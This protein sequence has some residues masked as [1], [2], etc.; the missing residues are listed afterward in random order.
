MRGS[1]N[2]ITSVEGEMDKIR[3]ILEVN[4]DV[5]TGEERDW[6]V[7]NDF[8]RLNESRRNDGSGRSKG[9]KSLNKKGRRV[10]RS[11]ISNYI[12]GKILEFKIE[13]IYMFW[14]Y[15]RRG[16]VGVRE[17]NKRQKYWVIEVTGE[18][19]RGIKTMLEREYRPR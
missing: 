14:K 4:D 8:K 10:V 2:V 17:G 1:I 3:S 9:F 7:E 15:R 19:I 18:T 12:I 6:G 16:R 11:H 13:I 5:G